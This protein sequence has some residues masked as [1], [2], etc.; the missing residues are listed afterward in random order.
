M[1]EANKQL[2]RRWFEEVW[3]KQREEA[4]DEMFAP[5]G[6]A[7]GFPEADS[8]LVGPESFKQI[9]RQFL[10]AF[11]DIHITIRELIAEGDRVAVTWTATMTHLGHALGFPPTMKKESLHGCSVLVVRVPQIQ[12]GTNYMEMQ[13]LIQ[14]LRDSSQLPPEDMQA[15]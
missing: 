14:R 5:E 2:V 12:E 3:N 6:K 8:V 1:S 9:Y 4:I 15:R 7:Y 10:G 11:P 13:A